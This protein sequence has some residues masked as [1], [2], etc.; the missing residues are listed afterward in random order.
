MDGGGTCDRAL[1]V[2]PGP[3]DCGYKPVGVG[4]QSEEICPAALVDERQEPPA[5]VDGAHDRSDDGCVQDV[6]QVSA[7][8]GEGEQPGGRGQDQEVGPERE[9]AVSEGYLPAR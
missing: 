8:H 7:W 6:Q 2:G 3:P 1:G 4:E 5:A 9:Q